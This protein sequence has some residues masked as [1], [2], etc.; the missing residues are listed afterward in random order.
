VLKILDVKA[1]GTNARI[2]EYQSKIRQ[3]LSDG[4]YKGKSTLS[5]DKGDSIILEK[6]FGG[7]YN[8]MLESGGKTMDIASNVSVDKA[9]RIMM[10]QAGF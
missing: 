5:L 4:N 7:R 1:D 3:A 6:W 9:I 10:E 8:L 2:K